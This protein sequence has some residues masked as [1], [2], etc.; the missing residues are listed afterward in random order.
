MLKILALAA[1]LGLASTGAQAAQWQIDHDNS[2]LTFEASQAGA[3]VP[4]QFRT[5]DAEIDFDPKTL[6]RRRSASPS[7]P[8]R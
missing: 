7:T 8:A 1:S 5:W 6:R 2:S 3:A 4:G